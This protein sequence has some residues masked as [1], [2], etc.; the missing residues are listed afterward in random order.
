MLQVISRNVF[1]HNKFNAM[2]GTRAEMAATSFW[3]LLG[4]LN[5]ESKHDSKST[6]KPEVHDVGPIFSNTAR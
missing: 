6:K 1:P 4:P 5:M 2:G 3:Q